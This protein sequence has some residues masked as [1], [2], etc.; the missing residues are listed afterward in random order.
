MA[1][2]TTMDWKTKILLSTLKWVFLT[3]GTLGIYP[4][5][6]IIKHFTKESDTNQTSSN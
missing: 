6:K 4:I 5:Y 2:V 3:I 1:V